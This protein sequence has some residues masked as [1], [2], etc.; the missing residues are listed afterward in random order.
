MYLISSIVA[1][2][3]Y[4]LSL[5]IIPLIYLDYIVDTTGGSMHYTAQWAYHISIV[6]KIKHSVAYRLRRTCLCCACCCEDGA[7][8][9]G[10]SHHSPPYLG[11]YTPCMYH[12]YHLC[13]GKRAH[14]PTNRQQLLRSHHRVWQFIFYLP[15]WLK[16]HCRLRSKF[17]CFLSPK[18]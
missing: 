7:V 1:T 4:H 10:G 15:A 2:R 13:N 18:V 16:P 6:R 17:F 5:C 14:Q 9:F 12:L 11:L 8:F 3:S